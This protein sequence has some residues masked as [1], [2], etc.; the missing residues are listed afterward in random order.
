MWQRIYNFHLEAS[1]NWMYLK[2]RLHT[3]L[4]FNRWMLSSTRLSVGGG[5]PQDSWDLVYLKFKP[6]TRKNSE[7]NMTLW[8]PGLPLYSPP[9]SSGGTLVIFLFFLSLILYS[10]LRWSDPRPASTGSCC[11]SS[12]VLCFFAGLAARPWYYWPWRRPL[13]WLIAIVT[14]RQ[15]CVI[16]YMCL[17]DQRC[18]SCVNPW[19]SMVLV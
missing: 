16:K 2:T 18:I 6:F 3:L 9:Y 5:R 4:R 8:S 17:L 19:K 1:R 11:S 15:Y 14:C 7:C 13:G 10:G 12:R